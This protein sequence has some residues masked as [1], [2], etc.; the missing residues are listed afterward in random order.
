MPTHN[1]PPLP[2]PHYT[3][4]EINPDTD[5]AQEYKQLIA[6]N[7]AT[8]AKWTNS[9]VNELGQLAQGVGDRLKGTGICFFI[10]RS[11]VPR[12]RKVTYGRIVV[13]LRPQKAEVKRTH[14]TVGGNLID[15]PSD[16]STKTA[17]LIT[18]KIIFNSVLSTPGAQFM[19]I[20]LKN[21]YLNTP[22]DRYEY[23]PLSIAI[24]PDKIIKQYNLLS[25]MHN[26]YIY[27]KIRKGMY[28]HKLA[29]LQTSY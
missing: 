15:Y 1:K 21:F 9:F 11:A 5:I 2:C 18:S 24:I 27:I 26:G 12:D 13:A 3:Y 14:L 8:A 29:S 17:D 19:G 7:P 10:A 16:V 23:M 20:D 4:S 28:S 6:N 25:L 22:L